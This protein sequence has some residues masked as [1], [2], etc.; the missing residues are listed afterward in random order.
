[1]KY[2][3][4]FLMSILFTFILSQKTDRKLQKS[5]KNV[6]RMRKFGQGRY[7]MYPDLD[8]DYDYFYTVL[9]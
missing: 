1:M 2:Y 6:F 4:T 8:T 7:G 3:F 5:K 9:R